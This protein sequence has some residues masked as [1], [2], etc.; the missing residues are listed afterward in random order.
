[1]KAALTVVCMYVRNSSMGVGGGGGD[2]P[3]L[4]QWLE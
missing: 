2:G 4:L 3:S 1:M